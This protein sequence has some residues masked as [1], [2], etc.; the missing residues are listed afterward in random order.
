MLLNIL[1]YTGQPLPRVSVVLVLRNPDLESESRKQKSREGNI[2]EPYLPLSWLDKCTQ[3]LPRKC[4]FLYTSITLYY[5]LL[6]LY[7]SS[8]L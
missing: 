8:I 5:S 6:G 3:V 2:S 7:L 1:Q 4:F